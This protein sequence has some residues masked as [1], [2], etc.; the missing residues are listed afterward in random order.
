MCLGVG[1]GGGCGLGV[2]GGDGCGDDGFTGSGG[3]RTCGVLGLGRGG[4]GVGAATSGGSTLVLVAELI[5]CTIIS[6]IQ[7]LGC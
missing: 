4:H 2:A 5:K 6:K 1:D 7:S 3:G